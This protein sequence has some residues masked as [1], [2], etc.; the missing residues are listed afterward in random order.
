M[1]ACAILVI[2][3]ESMVSVK[4]RVVSSSTVVSMCRRCNAGD[5]VVVLYKDNNILPV[6]DV[7]T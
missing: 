4:H 6:M 3:N 5:P 7:S 1:R 2:N